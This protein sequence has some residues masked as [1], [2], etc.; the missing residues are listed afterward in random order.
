MTPDQGKS[1]RLFSWTDVILTSLI[2]ALWDII[3][4]A[5]GFPSLLK[6]TSGQLAIS[7]VSLVVI[8]FAVKVAGMLFAALRKN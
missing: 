8:Y 1:K 5:L 6:H 2:V 4:D 3:S 7:F